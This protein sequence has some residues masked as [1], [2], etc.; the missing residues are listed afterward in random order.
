MIAFFAVTANAQASKV[1]FSVG[2]GIS[3]LSFSG[4]SS[5]ITGYGI[6]LNATNQLSEQIEGFAQLGYN[7]FS[8]HGFTL[9]VTPILFGAN[10]KVG[11]LKPGLGIGYGRLSGNG[12]TGDGIGGFAFSPQVGYAYDKFNFIGHYTSTSVNNGSFNIVGVKVLYSFN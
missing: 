11:A 12:P 3:S 4:G 6:E 2:G 1:K 5:S 9:G 8:D 7:S 10:I